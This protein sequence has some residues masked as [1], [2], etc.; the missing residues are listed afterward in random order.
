MKTVMRKLWHGFAPAGILLVLPLL[1]FAPVV[2]GDKTLLP[3]DVLYTFAPYSAAAESMGVTGVQNGL[4]ADLILQNYPW[5]RFLTTA[6]QTRELPLWDPY[7]FAGHPF[8]ANGQ[9]SALYPLT[10]IFFLLPLPRAFGVFIALQLGLAGIS[11]YI[12]A[13]TIGANRLGAFLAGATF[14]LSGFLV[15]SVVHPMIIAAASW[16]PLL[17][18]LVDLTVRRAR[19]LHQERAMLPWALCG[20]I[21][22]G[23]QILAGH[24]EITYFVLL[25]MA[26]FSAWRL[27]HTA[28]THPRAAWRAEVLSPALGLLLM[29][30]LGLMLGAIQL[31]PLYEV[32]S[33][34]FRQGSVTLAEV[35]GWAYPKRRLLAFLIPNFFG[36][37]THTTLWNFFTGETLRATVNAHGDAISAFDWGIKNY[38]EG[39]AYLGILPLLLALVAVI[40]PKSEVE[41]QRSKV[42]DGVLSWLR[43]PY[44]PFFTVLSLFSLGCIFGTPIYALVYALPFLSQSHSPFRWVFPLTVAVAALTGLGATKV[45]ESANRRISTSPNPTIPQSS[46]PPYVLHFTFYASRITYPPLQHRP[47][48]R[49]RHRCGRD[50][51][52]TGDVGRAVAF[53]AGVRAHRAA[54]GTRVLV[55]GAGSQCFPG[56]SRVLRL[57]VPLDSAYRDLPGQ[58]RHR[59]ASI[60][61]SHLL[62]QMVGTPAGVGSAGDHRAGGGPRRVWR[63]IQPR[64][65]P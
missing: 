5:K 40:S 47:Q 21:I 11:M 22:L 57:P 20:A 46:I 42:V 3:A 43:Q 32:V 10:W 30:G 52:G 36:N 59:A 58:R 7:I 64:R 26:M 55:A 29:V 44:V 48:R 50:L 37:P 53:A 27:A 18:T 63:G 2:L 38:V 49:E 56:S 16:L 65:Q 62:A 8:L 61:L 34:S 4:V 25:V 6:L 13:R 28:L 51:G 54:G 15:A 60:A 23:L 33:S 12:L 14:E 45:G 35:L 17:L 31:L 1:I 39:A 19:F 41:S 24:A 9:H